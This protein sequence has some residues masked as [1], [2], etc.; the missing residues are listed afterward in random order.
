MA[1][2]DVIMHKDPLASRSISLT[3]EC[4]RRQ[5]LAISSHTWTYLLSGDIFPH[6][7]GEIPGWEDDEG[8]QRMLGP[9]LAFPLKKADKTSNQVS[10]EVGYAT[11]VPPSESPYDPNTIRDKVI[12]WSPPE[13][14]A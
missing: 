11:K 2:Q 13:W 4:F 12:P 3:E 7:A 6:L 10:T 5:P 14:V 9:S 1:I 8:P